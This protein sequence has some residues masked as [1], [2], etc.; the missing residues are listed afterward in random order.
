[1]VSILLLQQVSKMTN[2][3]SKMAATDN[4]EFVR[5]DA[6]KTKLLRSIIANFNSPPAMEEDYEM[7]R[8]EYRS[9]VMCNREYLLQE[10]DKTTQEFDGYL[11]EMENERD[12]WYS[13]QY[14]YDA[15][16]I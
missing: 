12:K 2:T 3:Q 15:L 16:G 4:A 14:I 6:Q 9:R 5:I 7:Y 13:E 10:M 8:R 11:R 1:M